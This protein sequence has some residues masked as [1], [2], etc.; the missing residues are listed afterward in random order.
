MASL[1]KRKLALVQEGEEVLKKSRQE[2]EELHGESSVQPPEDGSARRKGPEETRLVTRDEQQQRVSQ[3]VEIY[4]LATA[5]QLAEQLFRCFQ[6]GR[7]EE[8]EVQLRGENQRLRDRNSELEGQLL[9]LQQADARREHKAQTAREAV[10]VAN[11]EHLRVT[12]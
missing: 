11:Q 4:D 7:L 10:V 1:L 6:E 9:Q 2:V 12:E 3:P 8:T 5:R